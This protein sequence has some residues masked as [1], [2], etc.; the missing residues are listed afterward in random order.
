MNIFERKNRHPK[1]GD[2]RRVVEIMEEYPEDMAGFYK[3]YLVC[4]RNEGDES[5]DWWKLM[6]VETGDTMSGGYCKE[7]VA[8]NK[9]GKEIL[10]Y[11]LA[12]ENRE[13][14]VF[15]NSDDAE[16]DTYW[17]EVDV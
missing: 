13:G 3:L 10:P 9:W 15:A 16:E 14:W 6:D 8:K 4:G 2:L 7:G 11:E 12:T 17:L 5:G 1:V